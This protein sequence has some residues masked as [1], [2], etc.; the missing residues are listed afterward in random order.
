MYVY[1]NHW[2]KKCGI[3]VHDFWNAGSSIS[4]QVVNL[5]R[6]C[7]CKFQPSCTMNPVM[8]HLNSK[9]DEPPFQQQ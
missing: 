9:S 3:V 4:G 2:F 1:Q 5:T 7:R 8:Y 6:I